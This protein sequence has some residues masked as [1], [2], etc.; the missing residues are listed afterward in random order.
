[1]RITWDNAKLGR[2]SSFR[3]TLVVDSIAKLHCCL[4]AKGI[5][6]NDHNPALGS[7]G[8]QRF[9]QSLKEVL[10]I[11]Y[12]RKAP[13]RKTLLRLN[14]VTPVLR[15]VVDVPVGVTILHFVIELLQDLNM[16]TLGRFTVMTVGHVEAV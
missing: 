6:N 1:C 13:L 4:I 2:Q 9:H 7:L 15:Q 16:R 14:A 11:R 3:V 8:K 10:L 12:S 5:T